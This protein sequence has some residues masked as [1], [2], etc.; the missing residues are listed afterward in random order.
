MSLE[1]KGV[2]IKLTNETLTMLH[3]EKRING[4]HINEIA[5]EILHVWAMKQINDSSIRLTMAK[6][7]DCDGLDGFISE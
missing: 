1:L 2:P 6:S 7:Q 3:A 5:R 4:G